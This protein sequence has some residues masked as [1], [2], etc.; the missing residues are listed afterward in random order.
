MKQSLTRKVRQTIASGILQVLKEEMDGVSIWTEQQLQLE[1]VEIGTAMND[2]ED[3]IGI[4]RQEQIVTVEERRQDKPINGEDNKKMHN[5]E[6]NLKSSSNVS[7]STANLLQKL[8]SACLFY[9][10]PITSV[11]AVRKVVQ[12]GNINSEKENYRVSFLRE[13]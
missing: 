4:Q 1:V 6:K 7:D 9:K 8:Q 10:R 13:K 11:N 2:K 5:E 3:V 12:E